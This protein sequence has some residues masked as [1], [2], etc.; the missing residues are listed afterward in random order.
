MPQV[1]VGLGPE[2]DALRQ[3]VA[4]AVETV[5]AADADV[6][7]VVGA[8]IGTAASS[9]APWA[10]GAPEVDIPVDIPEPLPLPLLVGAHLTR[11]RRRSFVV[12]DPDLDPG[13]CAEIGADLA[14]SAERVALLVM[15]DGSACHDEKAPGYV[16]ARAPEWEQ[17]VHQAFSQGDVG[18]L[19][20][21]DPA[22]AAELLVA[23]RGPWQVLAGAVGSWRPQQ[24]QARLHV[25]F[26]VGNHVVTWV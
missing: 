7:Y 3:E 26:G 5:T 2:V 13:E 14:A 6:L 12:I 10:P 25:V 11:G 15:G 16:D 8:G 17:G 4:A 18:F 19:T 21:L 22:L 9:F 1:G 23:G 20:A 24:V